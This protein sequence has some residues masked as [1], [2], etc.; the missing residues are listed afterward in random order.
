MFLLEGLPLSFYDYIIPHYSEKPIV[1]HK[2]NIKTCEECAKGLIYP[3]TAIFPLCEALTIRG[4]ILPL[5]G[6][7]G[8]EGLIWANRHILNTYT[9]C[10][11][12]RQA[13]RPFS[14]KGITRKRGASKFPYQP[15]QFPARIP[16][17]EAYCGNGQ[18]PHSKV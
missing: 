3:K 7:C 18:Y 17:P 6:K 1:N 11:F 14:Q 13:V 10:C 9:H 15:L 12:H 16:W 4:I 8:L 5:E 2:R